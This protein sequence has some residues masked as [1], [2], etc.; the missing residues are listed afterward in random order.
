MLVMLLKIT[1]L[2]NFFCKVDKEALVATYPPNVCKYE[3]EKC[4]RKQYC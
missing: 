4:A 3:K 1:I 2:I